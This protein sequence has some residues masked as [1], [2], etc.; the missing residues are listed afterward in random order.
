MCGGTAGEG[1]AEEVVWNAGR[2]EVKVGI[3]ELHGTLRI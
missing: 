1:E 2:D 3:W